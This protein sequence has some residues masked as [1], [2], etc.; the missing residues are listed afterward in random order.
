[1]SADLTC[2][3]RAFWRLRTLALGWMLLACGALYAQQRATIAERT[4]HYSIDVEGEGAE[5]EAQARELG[6]VM[7]QA[8]KGYADVLQCEPPLHQPAQ[9]RI[10]VRSDRASWL[11]ALAAVGIVP[12]HGLDY[13]YFDPQSATVYCYQQPSRWLTRRLALHGGL[14]QFHCKAKSK[15]ADMVNTWFV[16]GLAEQLSRHRWDGKTLELAAHPLVTAI[17]LPWQATRLLEGDLR[18]ETFA[19]AG[20]RRPALSWAQVTFLREAKEGRHRARFDKLALG[21]TG[22][23]LSGPE[24]ASS[25]GKPA[26][27]LGEMQ[28][29]LAS[30]QEPLQLV[31]GEFEDLDGH[32]LL[33]RAPAHDYSFALVREACS[34]LRARVAPDPDGAAGLL[35]DFIDPR[36]YSFATLSDRG[37]LVQRCDGVQS[38]TLGE[39]QAMPSKDGS[40]RMLARRSEGRVTLFVEERETASFEVA[41]DRLGLAVEKG[42]ARF[43]GVSWK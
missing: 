5:R 15:H 4:K 29:W 36:H 20:L 10:R 30:V 7:E 16:L 21:Q 1:M 35:L 24:F 17:D 27:I 22:S 39:Y 3:G 34:E 18:L 26:Q 41:G 6:A 25:L 14:Q 12:E 23:K 2:P 42:A 13:L 19:E 40:Q 32:T 11:S 8:W 28:S 37:I 33:G 9:F 38:T 31:C 43:F